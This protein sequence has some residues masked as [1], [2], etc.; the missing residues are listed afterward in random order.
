MLSIQPATL[1]FDASGTPCSREFGDIY[2]NAASG[3]GQARHVFLGGNDLPAR[4]AGARSFVIVE[5]GFGMG[6]NFLAT[7]KTWRDDPRRCTRL[8]FVSIE[9]HPFVAA[10]LATAHAL[11]PEFTDLARQ[12]RDAW[13]VL[14]PGLHR[15]HFE[16]EAVSLTLV[17]ADAANAARDLRLAAD[18]FYL[19]GFAPER[20]P[21]MWSPQLLRSLGRLA[22]PGATLSTWSV[23]RAVRDAVAAAGFVAARRPGFGGKR[24]MLAAHYA[25]RWPASHA[26]A[27]P[28]WR[29]RRAIV[30]GAGLAGAAAAARLAARGWLIDLVERAGAPGSAAS[31]LLAGAVQPHVSRDDCLLSRFTR[32]G[33][34]HAQRVRAPGIAGAPWRECGVLQLAGDAP[35]E[36]RIAAT[37]AQFAY[38]LEYAACV[39]RASASELAGAEVRAGGWWF[40]H[41]GLAQPGALVGADLASAG[42]Q[43]VTHFGREVARL[44]RLGER[45]CAIDAAGATI[46]AAPVV[47]LAN[48]LDAARLVDLGPD[49]LRSVRGQQSHLPSPPFIAPRAIV[50]GDGYVFPSIDGIA[51]AGATYDQD[52]LA[53][54]PDAIGH[55]ANLARVEHLLPG[56]TG[57]LAA[58]ALDG[59]VGFRCVATDRMPLAGALADVASALAQAQALTGARLHD[60]PRLSGLYGA[61]AFAS[62]GLAWTPLAA[63]LLASQIEGEP[64]PLEGALVDAIDPG[65]FIMHRL[66]RGT[67]E[68]AWSPAPGA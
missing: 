55:V 61:F 24:E 16:R 42:A 31:G 7:W 35:E 19:D 64:L 13:P 51:V 48:A 26:K 45:W 10:D 27:T 5:T 63:E 3:P 59:R 15:L 44:S 62:R 9:R 29:E 23:A 65:R 14:V 8:H 25:P 1:A 39:T 30:I 38:P 54:Q 40:P 20:N 57:R 36:T 6:L 52:G 22:A 58:A 49:S 37:A 33:Y 53:S 17:F 47:V 67:L 68:S 56:S 32:A 2:H 4:W 60:L 11:Y 46:S 50:G 28:E 34:L 66:R 43:V 12:L 18:A 21:D 41:G